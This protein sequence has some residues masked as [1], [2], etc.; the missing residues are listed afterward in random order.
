MTQPQRIL[1]GDAGTAIAVARWGEPA[2]GKP[3]ALLLH[4]TGFVAEVWSEVA[5]A[6]AADHTVYALDRRGHGLSHKPAADCYHFQD[7]AEDICMV[8]ERLG[9]HNIY[10]IGHSAGATDLLLATKLM[11]DR[12]ARLFVTEP[13]VMDPH[14]PRTGG[15]SEMSSASVQGALR[16]RA[17]FDSADALFQRL[18]TAPAFAPWTERSLW[19]YVHHG[20]AKLDDGRVR[21][22]CTP[23]I[24]SALLLPIV[25][26]MEQIYT[27]DARGNPFPWLSEITCP[28]CIATTEQSGSVYKLMADRAAALLPHAS[29]WT[30][31]GVGHCVAQEAPALKVAAVRTFA[32]RAE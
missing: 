8:V 6:L 21:L 13:T 22:R 17:E 19:A 32:R 1:V 31:D 30:F 29:R 12:F 4:G 3:P 26:A 5:E 24:E 14:A 9:L 11:P 27:G 15:L 18:R 10:G 2:S 20:F 7:F 23:E 16:R 28:V 25:Q